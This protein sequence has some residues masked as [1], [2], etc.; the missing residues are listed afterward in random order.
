M[1]KVLLTI[2]GIKNDVILCSPDVKVL[3]VRKGDAG[4]RDSAHTG[5]E[6]DVS[7]GEINTRNSE[8]ETKM[9][10]I[11]EGDVNNLGREMSSLQILDSESTQELRSIEYKIQFNL[12]DIS[13]LFVE[14]NPDTES[15]ELP[16]NVDVRIMLDGESY[17]PSKLA[18]NVLLFEKLEIG[19]IAN[20]KGGFGVNAQVRYMM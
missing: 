12:P 4:V 17:V 15:L 13:S 6:I 18:Y 19:S 8:K 9:T 3:M 16:N 1:V 7:Q 5:T 10:R 11:Q 20:P 2:P 14:G